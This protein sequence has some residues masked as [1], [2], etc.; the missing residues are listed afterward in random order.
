MSFFDIQNNL[1]SSNEYIFS[2][3]TSKDYLPF[4]INRGMSNFIDCVMHANEMNVRSNLSPNQQYDYY[5]HAI[6]PKKKRFAK[7]HKPAKDAT[8]AL[9]SEYYKCSISLAEQYATLLNDEQL[10][11]IKTKLEKGGK[12]G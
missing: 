9:I 11:L 12:R 8:T 5:H 10:A 1:T 6:T 4:M 2:D 7:W 3:E